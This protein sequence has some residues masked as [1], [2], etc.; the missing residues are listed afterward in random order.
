MIQHH[1]DERQIEEGFV[2]AVSELLSEKDEIIANLRIVR[3]T[4]C[5]TEEMEKEQRSLCD[6][7]SVLVKSMEGCIAENARFAQ[8]QE[9]YQ[10]RYDDL[11]TRYEAIK[12]RLDVVQDTIN[13]R[14][15]RYI[16]LGQ[17]IK[18]LGWC[19]KQ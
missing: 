3:A 13:S 17:F 1:V 14:T 12:N 19:P 5:S 18:T 8:D 9:T 11:T 6:E 16:A 7:L 15:A 2:A 10:R 4:L